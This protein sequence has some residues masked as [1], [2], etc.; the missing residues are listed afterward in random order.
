VSVVHVLIVTEVT[1][2]TVVTVVHVASFIVKIGRDFFMLL[3]E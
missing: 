2:V 3:C 1:V